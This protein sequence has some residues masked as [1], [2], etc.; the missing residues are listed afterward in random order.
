MGPLWRV[1]YRWEESIKMDHKEIGGD[2]VDWI[3][4]AQD[5]IQYKAVM[6]TAMHQLLKSD[7]SMELVSGGC[8]HP[9]YTETTD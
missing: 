2:G 5:R 9:S 8:Y 1:R 6:D 3:H 7:C 4:L